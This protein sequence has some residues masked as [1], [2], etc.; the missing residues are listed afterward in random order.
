MKNFFAKLASFFCKAW[1]W[2]LCLVLLLVVAIW[3]AGPFLA[4]NDH[5]FWESA[6]SRLISISVL[7]L[8]WGLSMVF[9]NWKSQVR[10]VEEEGDDIA[11]E[12]LRRADQ[13]DDEQVELRKR[14][15][16]ALRTLRSTSMY[17][18]RSDKWRNELPWYLMLGP[19]GSGKTSL[20][21]FSGLEFPLNQAESQR[22]TK[23]VSGTRHA[24]WYFAEHAVLV[25]TAGRYLTQP[26]SQI[27]GSAW[28]T[29][30]SLL[31]QR[32]TKPLNGVLVNIPLEQLQDN[33]ELDLENLAR[34]TRQRLHEI[35]QRL[36]VDVPVY[37][38]LSKADKVQGFDE[39]FDHMSREESDQ[40]LGTSFREDQDGTDAQEVRQEF[41]ELLRRLNSQVVMRMHQER[42]P[43]RR[44]RILDFPHQLG[45]IGD[46]LALFIELAFSGNRYQRASQ[47][48]GFYLTSAPRLHESLDP[49]TAEIGRQLGLS[50]RALPS[51][52]SGRSR[53]IHQLLSKV[54][55][56]EAALAGLDQ[57]EIRRID[58]GQRALYAGALG[59]LIAAGLGWAMSFSSNHEQLEE[60]RTIAQ[61]LDKERQAVDPRDD[62][63]QT[64]ATLE[65]SYAATQ[66]FPPSEDAAWSQRGGL[67]QGGYVDPTLQQAYRRDLETLLLPRVARQLESQ[68]RANMHERER[69][70]G[71]LRAYLMLNLPERR[72]APFLR[73]WMAADWSLRYVG[74]SAAQNALNN[75]FNNLLAGP[76][77]PHILN[78]SLVAQARKVLRSESLAN[79]V[80]RMLRE[81]A[82]S[83]PDYQ[84]GQRLGPQGALFSGIDYSIPGFYTQ[85]GYQ[86]Y[87]IAPGAT[88]VREIISNNW[89]LGEGE[90]LSIG[91]FRRLL[92]DV[93]H[94][95]FRDYTN[96]WGEA[97]AN[98]TLEPIGSALQGAEQLATLTAANS[99]LLALLSEI[100]DNT[101]FAGPAATDETLEIAKS[102]DGKLSQAAQLAAAA[103]Q[104]AQAAFAKNLPD[105]TRK[106][107]ERRFEPVHLLLDDDQ[108]PTANLATTLQA[109]EALQ[110]QLSGLAR[111]SA[112]EQ[113]AFEMAKLRMSAP[114]D[115]ISQV[116]TSAA[117]L[118]QPVSQWLG[119]LA[120]D[121]WMLVLHEAHHYINQRYQTELHESYRNS[122][123]QRYPFNPS[124]TS[125]VALADFRNFFKTQ[126][127][128]DTF[129]ER[130]IKP[131]VSDSSGHY[132]LRRVEGHSLPLSQALLTQLDKVRT[133]R[134][135]FFTENPNEPLILF[136]LEPYSLDSNLG[137]AD[138]RL[139]KQQMEYRHGPIVQTAFRWPDKDDEGRTSLMVEE[140]GGKKIG[141]EKNTGPWS[142]FRLLDVVEVD[143]HSG[144]DV[145]L[146][147]A[148]LD[149]RRASYLLHSQRSP[150]PFDVDLL[151]SFKLPT[152]L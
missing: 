101:R 145:L 92:V 50:N 52:R 87:F 70:L 104:Q 47:L 23:D 15:K 90:T 88:L 127:T 112:P 72:E 94:M 97:L 26:D 69:L 64:L 133:I 58:W 95:Y 27:D 98:I 75:H 16:E 65:I 148:N 134:H 10:K 33:S 131:F 149:G 67:Y 17:R 144:R 25:D 126:G 124:S 57:R 66:V 139:G 41:E 142:M 123:F 99:P 78:E 62:A 74:N 61:T 56:P 103:A 8:V 12:R 107:L 29:L 146:I 43:L 119:L 51:F 117:H 39:F 1:V 147:K 42:D 73:D 28:N 53:F 19:Q 82:R 96:Y 76:F 122:L 35:H 32:R 110:Q 85:H 68:I 4:V 113:T 120:E 34:Q 30:L 79:V 109:M 22:L 137:R 63:L 130:Y 46:R 37:L 125:D 45:Q 138:F 152:A 21:D 14:F 18:G 116:Y 86:Q 48:R 135:S 108:A 40:V 93:E 136:K 77:S 84:L 81:Q 91:E 2:S 59:C 13:I 44:G 80:Y 49:S 83:L 100:R 151:R 55:F 6:S 132:Q 24:D 118:P 150:N 140:I 3:F 141:I 9:A 106:A 111:A 129:F 54:I 71:S 121:S 38:V 11:Q 105:T 115:A 60:L 128:V 31:R 20:L 36:G 114:R 89:V 7:F 102:L 143:Y 5:K